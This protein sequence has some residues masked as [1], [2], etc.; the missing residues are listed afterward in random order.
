[1]QI[2][3]FR[4]R[5]KELREARGVGQNELA[6]LIGAA[7]PEVSRLENGARQLH[8]GWIN[9]FADALMVQRDELYEDRPP[10]I[11]NRIRERREALGISEQ[12]MANRLGWPPHKVKILEMAT[13]IPADDTIMRVSEIL[14]CGLSALWDE[15]EHLNSEEKAILDAYR[16]MG[17]PQRHAFHHF[18]GTFA[19]PKDG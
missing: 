14:D 17:E 10:L 19:K 8:E 5:I 12:E 3:K 13:R 4:N 9:R 11:A 1:M 2:M 6:I 15:P 7:P 18:V 16:A